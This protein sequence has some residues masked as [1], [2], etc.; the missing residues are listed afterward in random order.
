MKIIFKYFLI[1]LF[2]FTN[3]NLTQQ[4]PKIF[5]NEILASNVSVDADIVDF[6]DYSDWIEIYNDEIFDVDISGF[7]LTDNFNNPT[8]WEIPSGTII[9]AKGFLRFWA[10]G[11]DNYPGQTFRR[12]YYPYDYFTTKYYHLN[13]SLSR[14]SEE[15]GFFSPDTILVDSVSYNLQL[16]DI[17]MG[18]K[19]D[20]SSNWFYF[21]EPTPKASN[22]T[23]G[24]LNTNYSAEPNISLESGNYNSPQ[25]VSI[26]STNTNSLIKFTLDGSSPTS[27]SE[28][29]ISPILI[30]KNSVLKVRVFEE[31]KLPSKI[32][33]KSY[34]VNENFSIPV[35]SLSTEP[36]IL[37]DNSFGIYSNNFK[38]REIPISIDLIEPNGNLGISLNA[39]LRLTGQAS[40]FYPQKSF[41]ISADNRFGFDEIDYKFFSERN[42]T[43]FN[44]IYLRNAG[45]PDN[46]STFFR[47]ALQHSL[48]INKIDIDCQ[49]YQPSLVFINGNYWG[50]YNIR[51]KIDNNYLFALHNVNPENI[52]LLEYNG[53]SIP[54][55][56][57][58]D[59]D[60]YN[61][62]YSFIENSDLTIEENYNTVT[63]WMDIDEY[64]NYQ[65]SEIFFDNV[66]WPEQNMRMWR[67][68]KDGAKWRWILHDLDFG[69]GMP[70]QRSIGYA[71]NSLKLATSTKINNE[72]TPPMWSTLIFRKLLTN[73]DF[74]TIFIQR[75]SSYLN[76][77]FHQDTILSNIDKLRNAIA[78]EMPKHISRWRNGEYYYG[79]PIQ[80]LSEWQSNI[81]VMKEFG[82][83]RQF[84]QRQQI[85]DFFNLSG[86]SIV[87][88]N[89]EN[90]NLGNVLINSVE[91]VY[92][93]S[94]NIYFKDIPI[95]LKAVPDVGLKFVKWI[96]VAQE[97]ENQNP[98]I[99]PI[100]EDSLNISAQFEPISINTIPNVIS[101]NTT[102]SFTNSPYYA[103]GNIKVDSNVTLTIESGAEILM[104]E[105]S[106][107]LLNGCLLI[108]G[109]E[110]NPVIIKTNESSNN[111]GALCIV[112]STDSSII[113]NLK[114]IGATK[115][116]DNS[117]D[118]AA[119]STYN[120]NV[121][122]EGITVENV[123]A[124]I[125]SQYGNITIKNS[126][127]NTEYSGDLINIK[128]ANFALVENCELIGNDQFDSDGID[129]D[130]INS[131]IIRNNKIY[132]I[133]GFNS[134]AIDLGEGAKNILI[135]NNIIFNVNDK[136]VSIG[137]SSSGIIKRNVIANCGMGIGIKDHNSY[138]YSL[139]NTFY[140][141]QYAVACFEKNIGE[142]GGN[143]DVINCILADSKTSAILIDELS[144]INISYSLSNTEELTGINNLKLNQNL[145]IIYFYQ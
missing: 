51:E 99:F 39:G 134:D 95:E 27:N 82:E 17:S 144:N 58:G 53:N 68:K 115:G 65:I 124:P 26:T 31:N 97:L 24:I 137:N 14:S 108:N 100:V 59:A 74:K 139:N 46:R 28:T 55:V 143:A 29:Y 61:S 76:S 10:D 60:N 75:F 109:T 128:K 106:K 63:N 141:N 84:H 6:D 102:L 101:S 132:N 98:L 56:M 57:E 145:L 110:E 12:D 21:G 90:E 18:R 25:N 133:Y 22:I 47:D 91:T 103:L 71:N 140:G 13:F 129:Y 127:L 48:V 40:L 35:I 126:K 8:K 20:G 81:N 118:R 85:I 4:N 125:F 87:T 107:I 72:F 94:T 96:G 32:I 23:E 49:A 67:E 80:S 70:N 2:V 122:L 114:I 121:Y 77:I 5:I 45:V 37:F 86:L 131:G 119:I 104:P 54:E 142:G 62:F 120:S 66:F 73:N 1:I 69:F 135:E 117:R 7:Y 136:G 16:Q 105:N 79:N 3:K 130:E 89:F 78:P 52:D 19:P 41:T 112:N 30:D 64:I 43:I 123:Q 50:I 44:S 33:T 83:N 15:I 116:F 138:G 111:W 36:S 92:K 9:N 34:F 11:F 93:S 42:Y 113:K 38:E 88:I